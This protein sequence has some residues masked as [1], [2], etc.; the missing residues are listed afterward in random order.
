MFSRDLRR[1][2]GRG[3]EIRRRLRPSRHAERP[4]PSRPT[5]RAS[6]RGSLVPGVAAVTPV[7]FK[8]ENSVLIGRYNRGRRIWRDRRRELRAGGGAL[9]L[10]ASSIAPPPA[11]W[12][13][14]RPI[15]GAPRRRDSLPTTSRSRRA[16]TSKSCLRAGR[17]A[18]PSRRLP[19]RSVCS[20]TSRA[21]L[22]A[23]DLVANLQLLRVDDAREASGLL[24]RA[25]HEITATRALGPWRS[26]ASLGTGRVRSAQH[27]LHGDGARQG[28]VEPDG[29]QRPGP[30]GP[31]LALHA[32]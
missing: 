26:R 18:R 5:R 32:A 13:H 22:R 29:P 15:P 10:A 21:S 11:Q 16:I 19:R 3:L 12:R 31:G 17:S 27:R 30:G 24:P 1:G 14:S 25:H 8:L 9:G 20:R 6:R 23:R 2:E 4:E 7:V 28:S